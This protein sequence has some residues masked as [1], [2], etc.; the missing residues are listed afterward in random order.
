MI[1]VITSTLTIFLWGQA[2]HKRSVQGCKNK[3]KCRTLHPLSIRCATHR[4]AHHWG[5]LWKTKDT[6]KPRHHPLFPVQPSGLAQDNCWSAGA[7]SSALGITERF[8]NPQEPELMLICGV[9]K[10]SNFHTPPQSKVVLR[11]CKTSGAIVEGHATRDQR[12]PIMVQ[13]SSNA[14]YKSLRTMQ[15]NYGGIGSTKN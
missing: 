14:S 6:Y 2:E 10:Y 7:P 4:A 3:G 8:G 9:L 11:R 1:S 5:K 13:T 12:S 15:N